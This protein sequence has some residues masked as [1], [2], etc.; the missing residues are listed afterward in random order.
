MEFKQI[1]APKCCIF[2]RNVSSF[3]IP[4]NARTIPNTMF[5]KN[6]HVEVLKVT[7][8]W[9]VPYISRSVKLIR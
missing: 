3:N 5:T 7:G 2:F 1:K 8:S 9:E 4:G 6:T